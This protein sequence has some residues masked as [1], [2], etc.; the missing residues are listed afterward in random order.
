MMGVYNNRITNDILNMPIRSLG[1][2]RTQYDNRNI[3]EADLSFSNGFLPNEDFPKDAK[4]AILPTF[5]MEVGF[6]ESFSSLC[7]TARAYLVNPIVQMVIS[8]KIVGSFDSVKNLHQ[9]HTLLC[10]VY[11]KDQT[12]T[13]RV[14][15]VVNFG[16]PRRIRRDFVLGIVRETQFRSEK[17]E[18][19][20]FTYHGDYL[21]PANQPAFTVRVP[22]AVI[23]HGVSEEI[24]VQA[25]NMYGDKVQ[26]DFILDL[27]YIAQDFLRC[28][29]L[30]AD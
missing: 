18:G 15:R 24:V 29:F 14:T 17:F 27:R 12:N 21:F 7:S 11:E 8:I 26:Q 28:G 13:V 4:G 3:F 19:V 30:V 16:P 22:A 23:W 20:G 5:I 2:A 25:R 10:I 6:S 1:S 9:I